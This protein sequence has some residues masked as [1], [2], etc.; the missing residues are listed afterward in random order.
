M[1]KRFCTWFGS[2]E[3]VLLRLSEEEKTSIN[4]FISIRHIRDL[5]EGMTDTINKYNVIINQV[6]VDLICYQE[7]SSFSKDEFLFVRWCLRKT[8]NYTMNM[9]F[10]VALAIPNKCPICEINV[11]TKSIKQWPPN[12]GY[13]L[14]LTY[15]VR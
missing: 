3:V 2:N 5:R 8:N 1:N 14:A 15:R 4:R 12:T 13:L 9:C 7:L 6:W 10:H 11:N